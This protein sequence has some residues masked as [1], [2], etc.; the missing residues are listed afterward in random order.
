MAKTK[1]VYVC[2]HCGADSPKWLGKCPN[3]GEWNTYVEEVVTKEVPSA[4]RPVPS[5]LSERGQ[6]RPV[7]LRDITAEKE[8]R[9]DLKDQELN[10]VLGGGLVKGSLVLIGGEPGIGKSTLVLQTILKLHDLKVLYVSGEESYRQLKMR[11]DR[12]APDSQNC[13]ILC[14]T[15]LEQIFVQAQNVQPDLLIIDSIQTIFTELVESS[16]GSVSQV[17]ECSAAI[18]K[19]A[20]ES[21]VPVL[22]IGHINKEGSIAGPKVLEHIVDT[23]LQFEGDQHYMYRIL[24]SIK[25]RFGSTAELGIYEM[26]QEGLREV[27]NPSELLLTQNHEGLSGVA[28]AAAIEGIRPF[29]IETQAL[30]SSAVYGTPQRSAT[31]FDIRRMNMLLAV[32]EKRAGFKLAQKDVFLNI[33][34]GLR[35]NDPAIDLAVLAAV[36]SSSLDIS[37][38]PGVCMAGEVGLSGEIRPVN[39]IEQRIMEAE[40]L[41]FSRILIPYNNLKGFDTSRCRI[42]IVQVRKVEE[43]FRQLFG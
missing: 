4:K 19:F 30:V 27:S 18:L 12:L 17:R 33:A 20:K 11:A 7:L 21:G 16:P 24:R 14:E 32:L 2:S 13:L 35:V 1:T 8:D 9:L 37:I 34:G 36:L 38:E 29:L 31:G 40:K 41:G 42:Q 5:G 15:N 26:R 23:V 43:A 3:C 22:L 39:R 10:R 28:I 6:A 25:N